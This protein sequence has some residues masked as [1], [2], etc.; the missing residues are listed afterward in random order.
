MPMNRAFQTKTVLNKSHYA[1]RTRQQRYYQLYPRRMNRLLGRTG[2]GLLRI[3]P[4]GD[5]DVEGD[6]WVIPFAAL[7][8]LL[9]HDN[10][11]HG[12]TEDGV[13][14]RPRWLFH[15][16]RDRFVLYPG[17]RKPLEIDVR[18]FHGAPLPLP[19]EWEKLLEEEDSV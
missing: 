13:P 3:I 14:R 18:Q 7:K 15:I 1:V 6:F 4:I 11:T 16:M 5:S 10:L 9:V 8:D 19:Q 17:G 2:E 12:F